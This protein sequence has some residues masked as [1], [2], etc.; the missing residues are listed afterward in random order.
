MLGSTPLKGESDIVIKDVA[1][2]LLDGVRRKKGLAGLP[3]SNEAVSSPV[4]VA[5]P[6]AVVDIVPAG[7]SAAE[8]TLCE[9]VSV[10]PV[11]AA[12]QAATAP[13]ERK[14]WQPKVAVSASGEPAVPV[15]VPSTQP[16]SAPIV[17]TA[18]ASP[19]VPDPAASATTLPVPERKKWQPKS[20]DQKVQETAPATLTPETAPL[21]L[22]AQAPET[23]LV[24]ERKKWQPK[25]AV[26]DKPV[27]VAGGADASA[28]TLPPVT[29]A[30]TLVT[31]EELPDGGPVAVP[32]STAPPTRKKWN[33]RTKNESD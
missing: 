31:T 18:T 5:A 15:T 19:I 26:S 23:V 33:P 8:G 16:A 9:N 25:A 17:P 12:A 14:K 21:E 29:L 13:A 30:P 27:E 6:V 3:V 7:T 4:A 11:P 10:E 28:P 20:A 2:L 24:R 32:N 22:P 1:E